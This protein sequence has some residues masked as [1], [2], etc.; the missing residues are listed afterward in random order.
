MIADFLRDGARALP[1]HPDPAAVTALRIWHCKYSSLAGLSEFTNLETLV[2]ATY[3]DAGLGPLEGLLHLKYLSIMHFPKV[4]DLQPLSQLQRLRTVRLSTLPAW[5]SSGKKTI[6]RSL[7]PL[8]ELPELAHVELFGVLP[9]DG[10]LQA[11]E[12]CPAL[13][14]VR[15][16]KYRKSEVNRF[17]RI[18]ELRDSFAPSPGV[19]DWT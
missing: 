19:H 4:S 15:V 1:G 10:M 11:L 17:Y 8:A 18:T 12:R 9:E 16:S 14:S 13:E 7:V 5:D 3:P 2:I 6:V